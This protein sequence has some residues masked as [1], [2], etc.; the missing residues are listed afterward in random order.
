MTRL[1]ILLATALGLG[2]ILRAATFYAGVDRLALALVLAMAVA[3]LAGAAELLGRVRSADAL[4]AELARLPSPASEAA[5]DAASPALGRVLRARIAQAPLPIT[6][7]VFTPYLVGL[8]VML[9]LLGT[10]LGLFETLRGAREALTSSADVDALRAG[11]ARPMQGLT[12]SFGTSAAGVSA[13]AMLGLAAVFAR[14]A[15]ARWLGALGAYA[16]GALARLSTQARQLAALESLVLQGEALP[17]AAS[18]LEGAVTRLDALDRSWREAHAEATAETARAL[19]AVASDVRADLA[20]AIARAGTATH[21]AVS[22]LVE[23]AVAGTVAA[24]REHV[25]ELR[26]GLDA[27]R[28]AQRSRDEAH[29]ATLAS[30]VTR[31]A[32]AEEARAASLDARWVAL[33][34]SLAEGA[35]TLLRQA[36]AI[37]RAASSLDGAASRLEALERS[38]REAHAEASAE[39]SR[40]LVAVASDVRSDL[41]VAIGR[42]GDAVSPLLERAVAGAVAAAREHVDAV[43]AGLDADRASQKARDLERAGDVEAHVARLVDAEESR[44]ASLDARWQSLTAS[45]DEGARALVAQGSALPRAASSLGDAVTR[46]AALEQSWKD[47]HAEASQA[48]ARALR[49]VASEVRADLGLAITRGAAATHDAV[50]P[51]VERAVAGTVAAARAHV[52]ALRAGLDEDREGERARAEALASSV[53]A[54]VARLV[55]AEEARAASLDARWRGLTAGLGEGARALHD[56]L[57][58]AA[59]A[60]RAQLEATSA[61]HAARGGE[62]EALVARVDAVAA[63]LADSTG[64]QVE[65]VA[66]LVVALDE[67]ARTSAAGADARAMDLADHVNGAVEAHAASL[68][69]FEVEVARAHAA[70]A[71]EV[72]AHVNAHASL[73]EERL[74]ATASVVGDA[75]ELLRASGGELGAVTDGFAA[76]VARHQEAA[77]RWLEDLGAVEDAVERAGEGAAATALSET[78]VR[79]HEVFDR[80]LRVQI[81]L[82]SQLRAHRASG[83]DESDDSGDGDG[84]A[85]E[86]SG[87]DAPV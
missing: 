22:P 3:L 14:R 5:I 78:L 47:A 16:S 59:S 50:A 76:A 62:M 25:V 28:V 7:A 49:E 61:L 74:A 43:R 30:H 1:A 60:G 19:R 37:P 80:Q 13:S 75:A 46:L 56:E 29:A 54:H 66:S 79:L 40:A 86:R 9:G 36:E 31:L 38:W 72:A 27:D 17:R 81:E 55:E 4:R 85:E 39:T 48:S 84:D 87:G 71:A 8:L 20:T 33:T 6:G 34:A 21:E 23:R 52:D 45:L 42:A 11:L 67:R 15:E 70:A 12:R 68:A 41:A 69:R 51:L 44:A 73:L 26:A 83:V 77:T 65:A 2:T 32:S 53:E 24:A 82:F 57:A 35:G 18:S 63:S 64:R 10:F 58:A